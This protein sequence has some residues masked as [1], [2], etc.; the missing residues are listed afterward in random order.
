MNLLKP[1]NSKHHLFTY[2]E[3]RAKLVQVYGQPFS[4]DDHVWLQKET[5]RLHRQMPTVMIDEDFHK[6]LHRGEE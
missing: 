1:G 3:I 6:Q 5:R 2:P 4:D